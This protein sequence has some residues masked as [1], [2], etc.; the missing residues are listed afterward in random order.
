MCIDA[1]IDSAL[2]NERLSNLGGFFCLELTLV[3]GIE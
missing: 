1:D 3:D 2:T